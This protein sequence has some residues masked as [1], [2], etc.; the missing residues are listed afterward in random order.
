MLLGLLISISA[1]FLSGGDEILLEE[2]NSEMPPQIAVHN[3]EQELNSRDQ[4]DMGKRRE[5][6][7]EKIRLNQQRLEQLAKEIDSA[8]NEFKVAV[9]RGFSRPRE[10]AENLLNDLR[11]YSAAEAAFAAR[12]EFSTKIANELGGLGVSLP[13]AERNFVY[14]DNLHHSALRYVQAKKGLKVDIKSAI[15]TFDREINRIKTECI[16]IHLELKNLDTAGL[17]VL[18][19]ERAAKIRSI[20]LLRRLG[21]FLDGSL[22]PQVSS[23]NLHFTRI[24]TSELTKLLEDSEIRSA[25]IAQ[26][27]VDQQ[28]NSDVF[29]K[30]DEVVDNLSR[31]G[32]P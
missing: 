18:A 17:D 21:P 12:S 22:L 2:N 4:S 27:L 30:A 7:E 24:D 31:R 26:D 10:L 14:L 5:N 11:I 28:L 20:E 8:T 23:D 32:E 6:L 15:S 9:D 13:Q 16:A 29:F 3:A 25:T 1:L 19:E